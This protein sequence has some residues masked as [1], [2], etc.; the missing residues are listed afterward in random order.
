MTCAAVDAHV[1]IVDDDPAVSVVLAALLEQAAMRATCVESGKAALV[2]LAAAPVDVVV[3]DLR[4]AGMDGMELLDRVNR[5]HPGIPVIVISAHGT[6][7]LAV[8]AMRRGAADFILKPFD[9]QEIVYSVRKALAATAPA[10]ATAHLETELVGESQ[11]MADCRALL[12]RAARTAATVLLRGES[13]VGKDLAAREIHRLSGRS[14]GPFVK[15]HSGALPDSLLESELFGHEKG[16]FTGAAARKPGRM[17]LAEGGT[18]FLDEIGDITPAMQIKL[19]RVLQEREFERLGGT[20]TLRADVR[21]VAATHRDLEAMA[22]RG[23]FREDLYYRLSVVPIWVPPLRARRGDVA[24]LARRFAALL[25][26]Q[27]G[28]AGLALDG[29]AVER[30]T[31]E[32]WPGNVRQLQ[33]F[34]ERLV[35]LS[36]GPIVTAADVSRE[37][38]RR[39]ISAPEGPSP[40]ATEEGGGTAGLDARRRGAEREAIITALRQSGNNRTVAARIL[41]IS[42]RTLYAKLEEHDLR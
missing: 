16:A 38:A 41:G 23:D 11:E 8:E 34:V 15:V 18:L 25:A 22:R 5:V 19:L 4:M 27:H 21:F 42:R 33:N 35:V 7:R 20:Q 40:S 3:T 6:V 24:L 29:G 13:G 28:R 17:E 39:S 30:L 12:A 10:E 1:L 2:A 26:K 14:T 32:R 9:R 31:E 37:L 36:D